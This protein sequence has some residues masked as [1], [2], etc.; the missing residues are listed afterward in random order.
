M[1]AAVMDDWAGRLALTVLAAEHWLPA[2]RGAAAETPKPS[3]PFF[4]EP[5]AKETPARRGAK[6]GQQSELPLGGA[7]HDRG[8]FQDVAPTIYA[9]ADLDIP[10]YARRGIRIPS[11]TS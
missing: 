2:T 10:T 8:R 3:S 9:G 11:G 5:S 1:G 7:A 6:G 4:R